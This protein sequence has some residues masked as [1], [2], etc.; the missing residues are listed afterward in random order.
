MIRLR[1]YAEH[2][3]PSRTIR[4]TILIQ[5]LTLRKLDQNARAVCVRGGLKSLW[6]GD[7]G[8]INICVNPGGGD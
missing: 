5:N 2:A 1:T 6:D 8:Q 7:P 4:L 3:G